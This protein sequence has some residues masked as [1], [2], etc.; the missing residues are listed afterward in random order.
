VIAEGAGVVDGLTGGR[1]TVAPA[2]GPAPFACGL[3]ET[4]S[5]RTTRDVGAD[6]A[7]GRDAVPMPVIPVEGWLFWRRSR[8]LCRWL[9]AFGCSCSGLTGVVPNDPATLPAATAPVMIAAVVPRAPPPVSVEN[10]PTGAVVTA[11]S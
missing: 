3:G 1:L 5:P 11:G 6:A 9:L 10:P 8:S 7:I 2:P 4:E